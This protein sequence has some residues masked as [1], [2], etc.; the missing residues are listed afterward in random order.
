[1]R[2]GILGGSFDPVHNAHIAVARAVR[3]SLELDR[4]LLM[5]NNAAPYKKSFA[6]PSERLRMLELALKDVSGLEC[7]LT[8]I[9]LGGMSYT[10]RT[11][12]EIKKLYPEDELFYILG[13]DAA[14]RLPGWKNSEE[15]LKLVTIVAVTRDGSGEIPKGCETVSVD[16]GDISSTLVRQRVNGGQPITGLV[17]SR[18]ESFIAETGLYISPLSKQEILAKLRELVKPRRYVHTLGVAQT[19]VKLAREYGAPVGKAECAGLLHDCAKYFDREKMLAYADKAGADEYEKRA[20]GVLHAPAGAAAAK[21]L[22]GINDPEILSAIRRHTIGAS[23]MSMLDLIVYVADYIEPSR[24]PYDGVVRA[25]KAAFD[26][27]RLAA[28]ICAESSE[29]YI[30]HKGGE[31]HPL[32]YEMKKLKGE[33]LNG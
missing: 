16:A 8:E 32:I 3:E 12:L 27:I 9:E 23:D 11:L 4:V 1:M 15:V 20:E 31:I 2:T 24:E 29:D 30:R 26:D 6:T 14:S 21:E 10:Y 19:A 22:F 5:P 7:C 13:A 25:R 18:V 28:S 33:T 17:P